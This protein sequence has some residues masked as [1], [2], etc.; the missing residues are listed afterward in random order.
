MHVPSFSAQEVVAQI[1]H[2]SSRH[3]LSC[4]WETSTVSGLFVTESEWMLHVSK[5]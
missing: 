4:L 1:R 3:I 5:V 2:N